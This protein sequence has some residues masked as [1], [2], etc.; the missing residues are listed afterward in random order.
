MSEKKE[1]KEKRLSISKKHVK[2]Q[3]IPMWIGV[4]LAIFGMFA[5]EFFVGG[6]SSRLIGVPGGI[7]A[8]TFACVITFGNKC[9]Y[10]G[11]KKL[12]R[13][14]GGSLKETVECPDCK[15]KIDIK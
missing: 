13:A 1:K 11:S 8:L 5:P 15:K 10:C 9:P 12:G 7:M 14:I 2:M 4:V 3:L 6:L